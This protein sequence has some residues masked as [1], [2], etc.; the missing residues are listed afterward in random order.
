MKIHIIN[1]PNLNRLGKREPSLY[2]STGF[3][4]HLKKMKKEF[5]THRFTYFQSNI[6]GEIIDALHRSDEFDVVLLNPGGYCHTSVAIADAIASIDT[7]VIEVH[8]T[9]LFAREEFRHISI[10][11]KNCRG[12]I[13]GFGLCSYIIAVTAAE[14]LKE[15][16]QGS[17]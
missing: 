2:G 10:T 1:G 7:P 15:K 3:E 8:I 11:G 13:S 17:N 12:S 14:N 4:S 16:K 9:N 5:P 6:E